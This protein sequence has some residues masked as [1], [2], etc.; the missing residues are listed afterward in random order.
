MSTLQHLKK[1][2]HAGLLI[3]SY[4]QPLWVRR[5]IEEISSSSI[6]ETTLV[7][8]NEGANEWA[9]GVVATHTLNSADELTVVDCLVR[10][11]R[12]FGGGG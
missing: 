7:I 6:A 11:R 2:L 5:V 10:K 3:D 1:R 12:F 4:T 9:N 8:K